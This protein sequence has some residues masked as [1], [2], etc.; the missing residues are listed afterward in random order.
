MIVTVSRLMYDAIIGIQ[1][2]KGSLRTFPYVQ[3]LTDLRT[4]ELSVEVLRNEFSAGDYIQFL[5]SR[6]DD[7]YDSWFGEPI[8]YDHIA[9]LK[10]T[11]VLPSLDERQNTVLD[12]ILASVK[13]MK[14]LIINPKRFYLYLEA[15]HIINLPVMLLE[16]SGLVEYYLYVDKEIY[17]GNSVKRYTKTFEKLWKRM[18]KSMGDAVIGINHTL[19]V[20]DNSFD[21]IK[22]GSKIY[23]VRTN[24]MKRRNIKVGDTITFYNFSNIDETVTVLVVNRTRFDTFRQAYM[25]EKN[26]KLF[27][28]DADDDSET[29]LRKI[30]RIYSKEEEIKY[31]IIVFK[32]ELIEE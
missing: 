28:G 5:E 21:K 27:G 26:I 20:F 7:E 11:N 25:S 19:G 32:M 13:N 23:E 31:G 30:Y 1:N 12:I 15:R 9:T 14:K 22:N 10:Y 8:I 4:L 2:L 29:M 3:F 24:D 16:N 18:E 6:Y 17:V